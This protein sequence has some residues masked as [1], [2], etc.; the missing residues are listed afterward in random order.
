LINIGE[1]FLVINLIEKNDGEISNISQ[2]NIYNLNLQT[3]IFN[4]KNIH[5]K[6]KVFGLNYNGEIL[7]LNYFKFLYKL[8]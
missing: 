2:G 1:T 3:S 8:N 6:V 4:Y 7:Y 5:L